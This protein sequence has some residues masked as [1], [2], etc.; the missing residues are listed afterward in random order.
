MSKE[1]KQSSK[2]HVLM[3][4]QCELSFIYFYK[5]KVTCETF[6]YSYFLHAKYTRV[7]VAQ[8]LWEKNQ[9]LI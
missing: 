1:V 3:F 2:L 8:N 6:I 5:Y 4:I 7:M 9:Q